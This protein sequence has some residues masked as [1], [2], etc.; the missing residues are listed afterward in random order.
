M[1]Q[2]VLLRRVV[3]LG[4]FFVVLPCFLF[5][6]FNLPSTN[7]K[8]ER[9]DFGRESSGLVKNNGHT[10]DS[11]KLNVIEEGTEGIVYKDESFHTPVMRINGSLGKG[12]L[13]S[14]GDG[15]SKQIQTTTKEIKKVSAEVI[16]E[17]I[18]EMEDQVIMAQAYLR[19]AP[20]G[21]NSH[22]V[23]ELKLRIKEIQRVLAHTIANKRLSRSAL[24]KIRQMEATL[25]RAQAAYP[26]CAAMATKLRAMTYN[27]EEQLRT[28]QN[29]ASYLTQLVARTMPKGLHCL[30]L[31]L[32]SEYFGLDT[33]KR[34]FPRG[35]FVEDPQLYHYAVFSDNVLACS[36]VVNST[37]FNSKEA[38]KIVFHIITD[39]QNFPAMSAW[40]LLN[41]PSPATIQIQAIEN[42]KHLPSNF[43]SSFKFH[44]FGDLRF[45][46]RFNYLRFYL[47]QIFPSL[48]KILLLDHDVVVRKD[49]GELWRIDMEGY[50]NLAAE[51]CDNTGDSVNRIKTILNF[52]E[53]VV[54]SKFD[55]DTCIWAFG[56]NL[57]DLDEWRRLDLTDAFHKW[58]QLGK[59]GQLWKTGTLPI[60]QMVFYNHTMALDR[61]WHLLGLGQSSFRVV[62]ELE[63]ERA[64]VFH[65][66]GNM[67]P[68]LEMSIPKYRVYWVEYLNYNNSLLLK[69]NIHK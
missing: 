66:N 56:M 38:D 29:Q 68:W 47:P 32:I 7:S 61:R 62:S 24:Q 36:V 55:G 42:L 19:F 35:N 40:F 17:K 57:F 18:W 3:L 43:T 34:L 45:T 63:L 39:S 26:D 25:F 31:S 22:L 16:R 28:Q 64:T 53:P 59:E 41:P 12:G 23:K 8:S 6:M 33:E 44:D 15:S 49:L 21:S 51:A 10:S 67:K 46:S 1:R 37:I 14:D 60:G 11:H 54:A 4:L 5:M 13:V 20:P 9:E 27:T 30:S 50:V 69:C 65:Y 52:S 48:S 58:L 2:S